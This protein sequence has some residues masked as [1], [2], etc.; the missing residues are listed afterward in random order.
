MSNV[1][2]HE[3]V[4]AV[5]TNLAIFLDNEG[6]WTEA[7]QLYREVLE[8][9]RTRLGPDH[10]LVGYDM[11]SLG[12]FLCVAEQPA[13]GAQMIESAL[14]IHQSNLEDRHWR[15]GNAHQWLGL[16]LTHLSRFE[17]AER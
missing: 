10:L 9:D 4:T 5:M 2:E 1:P 6:E 15:I 13:E 7:E 17:D 16:C 11:V 8:I 3:E 12:A 14:P